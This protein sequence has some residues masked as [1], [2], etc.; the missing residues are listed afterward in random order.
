MH[1]KSLDTLLYTSKRR[2]GYHNAISF[3][4]KVEL[5]NDVVVGMMYLHGQQPEA[6]NNS[7]KQEQATR[8]DVYSFGIIMYEM[9]FEKQPYHDDNVQTDSVFTL[10]LR[11]VKNERPQIPNGIEVDVTPVELLQYIELMQQ[12]N[13][14]D[15]PSFVQIHSTFAEIRTKI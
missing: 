12:C 11:V 1:G 3:K 4:H 6:I 15:R 13:P 5:L 9:F 14:E 10:G 8:V 2:Q 7:V